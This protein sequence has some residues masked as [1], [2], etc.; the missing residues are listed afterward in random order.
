MTWPNITNTVFA[1]QKQGPA[2]TPWQNLMYVSADT[3]YPLILRDE[4]ATAQQQFYRVVAGDAPTL[5]SNLQV[6][7]SRQRRNCGTPAAWGVVITPDMTWVGS[8]GMSDPVGQEAAQ[9]NMRVNIASCTKMFTAALLLK[10]QEEGKL[11]LDDTLGKWL[12]NISNVTNTITLRQV[13][14]HTSGVYDWWNK[15]ALFPKPYL[16]NMERMWTPME[17]LSYIKGP[18]FTPGKGWEYSAVAYILAGLAAE[19]AIGEPLHQAWR[20]RFL[21]PVNLPSIWLKPQEAPTGEAAHPFS[22]YYGLPQ[23]DI[24]DEPDTA[25]YSSAWCSSSLMSS[26]M[27]LALWTRRL[28]KGEILGPDSMAQMTNM[29]TAAS[30]WGSAGLGTLEFSTSRGVF[31]GHFGDGWGYRCQVGHS[32]SRDTTVAF[33]INGEWGVADGAESWIR[34][35]EGW[36]A[37]VARLPVR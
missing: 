37:L 36:E 2:G 34:M 5:S 24:H 35:L 23:R 22:G 8:S 17:T 32:P 3:P 25:I 31:L 6:M 4:H 16:E 11:S 9:P 1:V 14:N 26:P 28:Y 13:L 20:N 27:D 10:L 15:G 18:T 21:V 33:A 29:V 7:L 19:A 30:G 12:P